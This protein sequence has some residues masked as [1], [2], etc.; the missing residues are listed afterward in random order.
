VPSSYQTVASIAA[1][2]S[3]SAPASSRSRTSTPSLSAAPMR[4]GAVRF[5]WAGSLPGMWRAAGVLAL[6]GLLLGACSAGSD[7]P[8]ELSVTTPGPAATAGTAA[9]TATTSLPAPNET[10]PIPTPTT[11]APAGPRQAY[12]GMATSWQRARGV[13]FTA[14]SDGRQRP[15][16]QQRALAATYLAAQKAFAAELTATSSPA[17]AQPA[18]R[19]LLAVNRQQQATIAGMAAAG[20]AGEFTT[21]LGRYGVLAGRESAA[22]TA[23]AKALG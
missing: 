18:V 13:F 17:G 4:C 14:I 5:R 20:S 12:Q 11:A 21:L 2:H 3:D 15:V 6:A 23:V 9:P 8:T 1:A 19:A 16:A 22:V 10:A 7:E